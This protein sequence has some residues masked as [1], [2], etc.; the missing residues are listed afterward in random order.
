MQLV[1]SILKLVNG[2]TRIQVL[3][4]SLGAV[5][6]SMATV[7]L[8][9]IIQVMQTLLGHLI[10]GISNPTVGLLE[11]GRTQ[12]LISMPPV[13][14]TGGG[15]A[16]TENTL[17]ETIEEKTIF[18]GLKIL[19]FVVGI[20][21]GLL[22]QPGLDGGVLLVEVGHVGDEISDDEHVRKRANGAF[23]IVVLNLGKASQTVLAVHVHS[24][25]T[26][27]TFTA[28]SIFDTLI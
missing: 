27:N 3:G 28:R 8:V 26:A 19:D 16:S 17:V 12:V 7:K 24:T 9:S 25:G 22:L 5:H 21:L 6:N 1:T 4:T 18:V 10:A 20:H 11:D 14:R 15:A 13:G 2:T 23:L